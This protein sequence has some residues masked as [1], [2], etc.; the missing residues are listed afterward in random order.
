MTTRSKRL[1]RSGRRQYVRRLDHG[2][3]L[4]AEVSPCVFMYPGYPLQ[5]SVTLHGPSGELLGGA[6]TVDRA[7]TAKTCTDATVRRLLSTVRI[8]P[9][10]EC[11]APAFDPA[12]VETN[13]GGL[14]EPCFL[15]RLQA[16]W[17]AEIEAEH[18][19]IAARDRRMKQSGKTA[20][21]TAWIHPKSGDD[22][23]VDWYLDTYP[24]PQEVA[25]LLREAG[26]ICLDDYQIIAL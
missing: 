12:T 8:S 16:E 2:N 22:Y 1:Q 13:R 25:G 11:S 5:L 10:S 21:L 14:C 24:T 15:K 23:Q 20:R 3:T 7:K 18:S 4:K 17:D 9:C 26:S 19:K 6:H